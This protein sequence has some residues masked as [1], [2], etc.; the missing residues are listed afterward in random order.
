MYL[1]QKLARTAAMTGNVGSFHYLTRGDGYRFNHQLNASFD[2]IKKAGKIFLIGTDINMD[3]AV[4][5]F[6]VNNGR[7]KDSIPVVLVTNK[8]ESSM[9]HKVD[10]VIKV[11][12]YYYFIKAVNHFLVTFGLGNELF[13]RDR[14][15]GQDE[16]QAQLLEEDFTKLVSNAGVLPKVIREFAE[17]YNNEMNAI[18]IFSE[19]E[20]SSNCSLELFNLSMIAGKLGKTANGLITL[21]EKNNSQGLF[22]MGISRHTGVGGIPLD[23]TTFINK[24][25]EVWNVKDLPGIVPDCL[26]VKLSHEKIKNLFIFGEDPIGCDSS[27]SYASLIKHIP[28][29][30]VQDYFMT[31]TAKE[32]DLILPASFPTEIGGTFSNTQ[33]T[34]LEFE[35]VLPSRVEL[36][37]IMQLIGLFKK[38]GLNGLESRED[39]FAEIIRLLPQIE[40]DQPEESLTM[41]FTEEDNQNRSFNY[42][43]DYLV[44]R[45]E[46]G[47]EER[48]R[49]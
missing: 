29:K 15:I 1:I 37:S 5:G 43:C 17:E 21:K 11:K 4:A 38:F 12:S 42:G 32:A 2:S 36:S 40:E 3:H 27:Q 48:L 19:K 33:K 10:K 49:V 35:P 34:I 13:L 47:F 14:V 26:K 9:V 41:V 24:L 23:D 44:K 20:I 39:V 28:F 25:K 46:E 22:D 18:A 30:V 6:M 16:Y 8:E 7:V 45:F 31:D